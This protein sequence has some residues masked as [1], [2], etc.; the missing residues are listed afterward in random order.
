MTDDFNE[1]DAVAWPSYVDFLFSFC[2]ILLLALGY[3]AF[4]SVH[5]VEGED[6]QRE[7]LAGTA[8]L[9]QL[10]LTPTVN[11]NERRIS[12]PLPF[13]SFDVGCPG[14]PGCSS[15][16]DDQKTMLQRVAR[17]LST[18]Y[19]GSDRIRL[20][21]QADRLQGS[22]RFK[23]FRIASERAIAVYEVFLE[24]KD[25]GLAKVN[26]RLQKV[27]LDNVGEANAAQQGDGKQDRTVTIIV[28]YAQ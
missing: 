2:F 10:D 17:L 9:K 18:E 3:M 22:S 16:S 15:L 6:F 21:G 26:D 12:I 1:D 11:W 5:G 20:Q 25:C 23:N 28:D 19:V 8:S 13:I 27:Q 4:L 24:C 7:A 14:K